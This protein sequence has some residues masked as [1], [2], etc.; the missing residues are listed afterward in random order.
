MSELKLRNCSELIKALSENEKKYIL[1]KVK[2]KNLFLGIRNDLLIIY[3]FGAKAITVSLDKEKRIIY[4]PEFY[5]NKKNE[6]EFS[7]EDLKNNFE[8]IISS[9]KHV[10]MGENERKKIFFEKICQQWIVNTANNDEKNEWYYVD[11]EYANQGINIGRFDMVAI[12][13][14]SVSEKHRVRLIELKVRADSYQ[15]NWNKEDPKFKSIKKYPNNLF[16]EENIN[17]SFGS[18]IVG[19]ITDF[20]RFFHEKKYYDNLKKNIIS[21]FNCNR[22]LGIKVPEISDENAFEEKPEVLIA[23]YTHCPYYA[24]DDIYHDLTD[25]QKELISKKNNKCKIESLK[26]KTRNRLLNIPKSSCYNLELALHEEIISDFLNLK[27]TDFKNP[28]EIWQQIGEEKYKF[29]FFFINA[30]TEN[31]WNLI[32]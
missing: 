12:S 13:K 1:N 16:L 29:T 7:F 11:M 5:N 6:E 4:K 25:S 20:L 28:Q 26:K 30:D 22:E 17:L 18:G 8:D 23:T 9:A 32:K 31:C 19:H 27:H 15:D 14:H 2:D 10:Y 21:I 3:T 24:Y